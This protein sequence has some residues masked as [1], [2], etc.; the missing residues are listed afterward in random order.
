M[1]NYLCLLKTSCDLAR[2]TDARQLGTKVDLH[3]SSQ[4][5]CADLHSHPP[6]LLK[7]SNRHIYLIVYDQPLTLGRMILL[8]QGKGATS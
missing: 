5:K 8:L 6:Y 7:F 4:I 2:V 3:S 1:E